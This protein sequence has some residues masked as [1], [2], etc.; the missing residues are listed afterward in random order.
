MV[1]VHDLHEL[2]MKG[3]PMTPV[4]HDLRKTVGDLLEGYYWD[5]INCSSSLGREV[6][7]KKAVTEILS[8]LRPALPGNAAAPV[9]M[10]LYCPY[11][12]FQHIDTGE[13]V[14]KPHKRHLC[15]NP[16]C[17]LQ[18]VPARIPTVGVEELDYS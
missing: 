5:R 12:F 15:L 3:S 4:T 14:T 1:R 13:W 2:R 16:K 11:C 10:V 9:P 17:G 6:C 8:L 7:Q 18:F